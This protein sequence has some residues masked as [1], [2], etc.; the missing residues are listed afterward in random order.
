MPLAC[1]LARATSKTMKMQNSF[2]AASRTG[3]LGISRGAL[4]NSA[5][6]W[7]AVLGDLRGLDLAPIAAPR[8]NT[9]FGS[10]LNFGSIGPSI[11][12]TSAKP[13]TGCARVNAKHAPVRKHASRRRHT[14]D[15]QELLGAVRAYRICYVLCAYQ[16]G[17]VGGGIF[18]WD[19]LGQD[20]NKPL[21]RIAD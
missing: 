7:L 1:N 10:C 18:A 17:S 5:T 8:R 15:C 14:A 3:P 16:Q 6:L 21:Q 2:P 19:G 13:S 9:T 11:I 20:C 4:I 12:S